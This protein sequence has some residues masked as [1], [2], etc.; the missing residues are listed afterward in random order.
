PPPPTLEKLISA[1]V[2]IELPLV[3]AVSAEGRTPAAKSAE[4]GALMLRLSAI[5]LKALRITDWRLRAAGVIAAWNVFQHF[6]PYIDMMGGRWEDVL[7]PALRRMLTDRSGQDHQATLSEMVAHLQ[8]GHGYVSPSPV[9]GGLPIRV[10]VVDDQLVVTGAEQESPF[11][12][13]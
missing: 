5:D 3:L 8:D 7:R 9:R 12:K 6:H 2:A 13:G 1:D 10:E 11:R 4:F